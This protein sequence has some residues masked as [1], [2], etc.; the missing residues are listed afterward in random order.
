MAAIAGGLITRARVQQ[1]VDAVQAAIRGD[2]A[3]PAGL[4]ARVVACGI[5]DA[6]VMDWGGTFKLRAAV[7]LPK[8]YALR[9][10]SSADELGVAVDGARDVIH[11]VLRHVGLDLPD[12]DMSIGI[13][14]IARGD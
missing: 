11:D 6:E 4:V 12:A 10:A 2:A 5:R 13:R 8:H 7:L 14:S 9:G 3:Y 1:S